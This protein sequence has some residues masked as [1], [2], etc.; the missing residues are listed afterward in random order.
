MKERGLK[1]K[2]KKKKGGKKSKESEIIYLCRKCLMSDFH[3]KC[4]LLLKNS[5][6]SGPSNRPKRGESPPAEKNVNLFFSIWGKKKKKGGGRE[7]LG[8]SPPA[9]LLLQ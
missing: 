4:C 6:D 9:S 8:I 1:I 7:F 5:Q 3:K 2:T